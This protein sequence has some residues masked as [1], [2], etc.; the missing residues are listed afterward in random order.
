MWPFVAV[1]QSLLISSSCLLLP[2]YGFEDLVADARKLDAFP[3]ELFDCIFDKGETI[4][5]RSHTWE[6]G[7]TI[8]VHL[9]VL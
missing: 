9:H 1:S 4:P 2:T 7:S 3:D 8:A 6:R 5:K